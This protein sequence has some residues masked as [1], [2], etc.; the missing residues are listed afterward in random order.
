MGSG[1]KLVGDTGDAIAVIMGRVAE[2]DELAAGAAA[3]AESQAENLKHVVA[4]VSEADRAARDGK[5]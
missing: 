5:A 3:A 2:I 4:A 1:V